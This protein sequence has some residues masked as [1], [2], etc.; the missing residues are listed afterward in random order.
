M[1]MHSLPIETQYDSVAYYTVHCDETGSQC[2][3]F[4]ETLPH[5]LAR[6]LPFAPCIYM[7]QSFSKIE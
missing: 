6:I 3:R 5:F 1:Y 4:L 7:Y 2:F